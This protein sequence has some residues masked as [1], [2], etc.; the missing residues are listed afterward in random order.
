MNFSNIGEPVAIIKTPEKHLKKGGRPNKGDEDK[1][2]NQCEFCFKKVS[3][4]N[5]TRHLR[6]CPVR[7]AGLEKNAKLISVHEFIPQ[8]KDYFTEYECKDNEKMEVIPNKKQA[9]Q[10]IYV[11]GKSG[12]GK[13]YFASQYIQKYVKM[14]PDNGVFLFSAVG[15]DKCLDEIKKLKRIDISNE[16]FLSAEL[17]IM[18]VRREERK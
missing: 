13:S 5:K 3:R 16:K 11:T 15:D 2:Y 12:S 9:R 14:Y 18:D 1:N 8:I 4:N 7:K 10:I 17:S 6:V